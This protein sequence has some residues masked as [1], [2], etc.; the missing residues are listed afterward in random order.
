MTDVSRSRRIALPLLALV[1]AGGAAAILYGIAAPGSKD[2]GAA[3]ACAATQAMHARLDPLVHGEVAALTL[4]KQSRPLPDLVFKGPDGVPVHL[5]DF[6]GKPVLLNLWATWCV[7]CR[8]EMPALDHLQADLR[9]DAM[10]V[11]AVNIDTARL[12]RPKAFLSE[13]GVRSLPFYADPSADVFQVL[14]GAGKVVGLPTTILVGRDG[15][16]IGTMAGPAE[17][18]SPDAKALLNAAAG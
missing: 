11:V 6:R 18:D 1:V 9:P 12:D 15:C 10:S 7:P 8:Q 13:I 4:P 16:E 3:A 2:A 17:W 5:S 14:K